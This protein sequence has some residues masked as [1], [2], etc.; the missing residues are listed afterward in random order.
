MHFGKKLFSQVVKK[1][2]VLCYSQI[3]CDC[4]G[5]IGVNVNP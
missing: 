1:I 2:F 4:G 5:V 3:L